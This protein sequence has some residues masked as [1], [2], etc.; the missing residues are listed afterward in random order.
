MTQMMPALVRL[1]HHFLIG[2]FIP[3]PHQRTRARVFSQTA[4]KRAATAPRPMTRDRP[5]T[6]PLADAPEELVLELELEVEVPVELLSLSSVEVAVLE[7]LADDAVVV[8][9]EPP[10]MPLAPALPVAAEPPEVKV[11]KVLWTAVPVATTEDTPDA[12]TAEP[13]GTADWA[14]AARG[15]TARRAR[16]VSCLGEYILTGRVEQMQRRGRKL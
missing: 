14:T 12:E 8:E 6:T 2:G 9:L 13:V 16:M 11:A 15:E 3:T 4:Q 10:E 5:P 1:P 7:D